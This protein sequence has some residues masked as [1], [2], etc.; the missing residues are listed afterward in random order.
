MTK[1]VT[2]FIQFFSKTA[3]I[4]GCKNVHICTFAIVTVQ[5][6]TGT[7]AMYNNFFFFISPLSDYFIPMFTTTQQN[8]RRR[9]KKQRITTNLV[10]PPPPPP[11]NQHQH[12]SFEHLIIHHKVD[13]KSTDQ[14][15][16][17][18]IKPNQ[19]QA[20]PT[21]KPNSKSIK[22]HWEIQ[23]KNNTNPLGNPIQ[24][25]FKLTGKPSQTKIKTKPQM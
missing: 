22:T 13:P 23:L 4:S 1:K 14:K 11:P 8:I 3:H 19:N 5:I 25:Q 6:C 15:T 16:Q 10:A 7:V 12:K 17:L 18:K 20:K 24:N 2:K 9:R 21:R